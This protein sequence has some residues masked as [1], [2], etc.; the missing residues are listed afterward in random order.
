VALSRLRR[1]LTTLMVMRRTRRMRRSIQ[2]RALR[3]TRR[4]VIVLSLD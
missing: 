3:M 4:C 2:M 1:R